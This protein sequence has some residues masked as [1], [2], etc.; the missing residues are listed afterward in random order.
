MGETVDDEGRT[1]VNDAG[2]GAC[3][4]ASAPPAGE[5]EANVMAAGAPPAGAGD[6]M[7]VSILVPTYN[8]ANYIGECLDSLLAQTEP[9]LEII[10][11]DDGSEDGTADLLRAY[12]E[13]IRYV[14]KENGGKPSAVNLGLAL[15]RG[16]LIWIF[17]DDDVAL[18]DAIASR[19]AALRARPDAGFVF[20]SHYYGS[21]DAQGRIVR[22]RPHVAPAYGDD[23]FFAELMKGC[24]FHLATALVRA[25]VY[26]EVGGFDAELLSSEDYDMQLRLARHCPAAFSPAPSFI[27]RQH[28]GLRGAKAIRYAGRQRASV[29]RRFDQRVGRKLRATLPLGDYLVPRQ[30]GALAAEATRQALLARMVVM[31]SKGCIA[32][33]FDDLRTLLGSPGRDDVL[34]E[35]EA[36]SVTAAIC[37]GYAAEA[38]RAEWADFMREVATLKRYAAGGA[39][40]RALARGFYRMARGY[41]G[42]FALRAARLRAA[43]QLHLSALR[44]AAARDVT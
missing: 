6:G 3:G 18:P 13:R 30:P 44:A 20:S 38:C 42:S 34:H 17:D 31:G 40:I 1:V 32:E 19:T 9:A 37:T 7:S 10:V 29:F 22:G 5:A 33:L 25:E 12:G 24:F 21:D 16:Q 2:S 27:F 39:A 36:A 14:R 8:R 35:H 43:A 41:P 23:R 15:A 26:R 11:I 28:G 4:T